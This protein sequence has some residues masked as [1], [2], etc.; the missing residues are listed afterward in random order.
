MAPEPPAGVVLDFDGVILD[1]VG[2][3][4]EAFRRLFAAEGPGPQARIVA[5]HQANGGISRFEKFRWAYREVLKRQLSHEEERTLGLRFNALV[6][7]AVMA[8]EFIPGALEF[9]EGF[10]DRLPLFVASGTPEDELRRIVLSRGLAGHFKA[11]R[12]SPA[13]KADILGE[14]AAGL[15]ASAA[16]LVMVGDA[17]NDLDAAREA[18]AAF[19]GIGRGFP[20]GVDVLPDLRG[21]PAALG[22]A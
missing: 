19:I 13:R 16:D 22:L 8:A 9:L 3:K 11:V 12:G 1:S 7:D 10:S 4:T 5:H 15:G 20:D 21:L 14:V 6:E 18:G 2:V 17:V